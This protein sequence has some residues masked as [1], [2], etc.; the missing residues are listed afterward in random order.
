MDSREI[1]DIEVRDDKDSPWGETVIFLVSCAVLLVAWLI[2]MAL[3]GK[4]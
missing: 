2:S 4:F 1:E 3:P